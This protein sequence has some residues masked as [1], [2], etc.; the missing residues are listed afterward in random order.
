MNHPS[1]KS[2]YSPSPTS[3]SSPSSFLSARTADAVARTRITVR[4]DVGEISGKMMN[5]NTIESKTCDV[6]SIMLIPDPPSDTTTT[7][8]GMRF[9]TRVKGRRTRG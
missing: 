8:E 7:M 6:M 1:L 4:E 5:G 9:N 3:S 2:R